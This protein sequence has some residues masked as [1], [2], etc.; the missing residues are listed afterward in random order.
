MF[1]RLILLNLVTF[2]LLPHVPAEIRAQRQNWMGLPYAPVRASAFQQTTISVAPRSRQDAIKEQERRAVRE[3][4]RES[5]RDL[6]LLGIG[7][8]K[9]HERRELKS[10]RL[11]KDAKSIQRRARTIRGLMVLGE[12]SSPPENFD[13]EMSTTGDFDRSIRKLAALIHSFAHNPI[14]K[15]TKVFNTD[16]AAKALSD[17]I[18][19]INLAKVIEDRAANY[20]SAPIAERN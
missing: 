16:Q 17:L 2:S 15:N 11:A 18:N 10:G 5:F 14:H 8:L 12:P 9:A 6:Q 4:F 20:D 1:R 7:L 19:I 13:K 3:Q